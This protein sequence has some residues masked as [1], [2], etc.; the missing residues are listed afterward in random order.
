MPIQRCQSGS[1]A[2]VVR[3]QDGALATDSS[4]NGRNP[5]IGRVTVVHKRSCGVGYRPAGDEEIAV[6]DAGLG[7]ECCGTRDAWCTRCRGGA[8]GLNGSASM[9]LVDGGAGADLVAQV[10]AMLGLAGAARA[11]IW[12]RWRRRWG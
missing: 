7:R 6:S 1:I 5:D 4:G 8:D 9:G 11:L 10:L 3:V 2:L 12:R